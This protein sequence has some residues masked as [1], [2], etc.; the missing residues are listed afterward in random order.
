MARS[1]KSSRWVRHFFMKACPVCKTMNDHLHVKNGDK[2]EW[3]YLSIKRRTGLAPDPN[4]NGSINV[5][6]DETFL[7]HIC[8]N[9]G[10]LY[11]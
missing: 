1:Q 2:Y 8:Q 9:C 3:R 4:G 7:F 11:R 5:F 10:V 6:V